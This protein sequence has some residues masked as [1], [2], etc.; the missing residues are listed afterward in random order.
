[1]IWG[2]P[3]VF[4]GFSECWQFDLWF[5]YLFW[6][7]LDI[8]FT[9]IASYSVRDLFILLTVVSFTLKRFLVWRSF[10]YFLLLFPLL[11]ETYPKSIFTKTDVKELTVCFLLEVLWFQILHLSLQYTLN[12]FLC[13]VCEITP[14]W[15]F[16]IYL[17]NFPNT[18]YR[19]DCHFSLYILPLLSQINCPECGFI[20]W[21]FCFTDPLPVVVIV[22]QLLSN[23]Q[24]FVT[25]CTVA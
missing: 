12:L 7:L 10:V 5:L 19:R 20:S 9:S 13:L 8:S 18:I 1:M 14:I 24:L 22:V 21:L 15:F 17:S 25:P 6:P 23:V 3:L 11:E 16:C 4:L 2:I